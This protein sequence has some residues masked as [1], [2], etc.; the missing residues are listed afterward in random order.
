M[1]HTFIPLPVITFYI[2]CSDCLQV[3]QCSYS[4]A[5]TFILLNLAKR[6]KSV[7]WKS[8]E[9]FNPEEQPLKSQASDVSNNMEKV[10]SFQ[11]IDETSTCLNDLNLTTEIPP[12]NKNGS[13][14]ISNEFNPFKLASHHDSSTPPNPP[15]SVGQSPDTPLKTSGETSDSTAKVQ[16]SEAEVPSPTQSSTDSPSKAVKVALPASPP[17]P[18]FYRLTPD[19][20]DKPSFTGIA[21]LGNT[22]FM[23]SVLQCLS[24]TV[25][26]RDY[27]L[28]GFYKE[29]INLVN[30]LGHK[31]LLAECFSACLN[32]LWRGGK[33]FITPRK[34]KVQFLQLNV[35]TVLLLR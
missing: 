15:S 23:S 1:F 12:G 32:S 29:E 8:L 16:S 6:N 18:S 33:D 22:C 20:F 19:P 34:L 28:G 24:N 26:V 31:G 17:P 13:V 25:E 27:F 7:M 10:S 30:P 14:Y 21:N 5:D 9:K 2:S 3:E 4:V 11:Q 35:F